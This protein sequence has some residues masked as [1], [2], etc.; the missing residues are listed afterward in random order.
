MV[1][2]LSNLVFLYVSTNLIAV[3]VAFSASNQGYLFTASTWNRQITISK[4]PFSSSSRIQLHGSSTS[5]SLD[6]DTIK[7]ELCNLLQSTPGNVPTPTDLTQQILSKVQ[8][9][10]QVSENSDKDILQ[11]LSGNWELLWTTQD[12]SSLESQQ[13]LSWIK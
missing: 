11:E 10:E 1:A 8:T 12:K 9:L 3:I 2:V 5:V 7:Q 6:R 4:S 13:T